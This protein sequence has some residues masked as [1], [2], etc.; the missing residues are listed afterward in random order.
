M[1]DNNEENMGELEF[2]ELEYKYSADD[3]SLEDF[4]KV[5]MNVRKNYPS[6]E[7]RIVEVSSWDT[8][9]TNGKDE[10]IRY[11]DSQVKPELTIKR[12]TQ[13]ANN[14]HRI[15]VNLPLDLR[16]M[17]SEEREK[18]V[19]EFTSLLGFTEN[20][21]IYKTCF[22]YFIGD[23]NYVY[24]IVYDRHMKE[25]RRFLE[26]EFSEER[27]KHFNSDEVFKKLN[28]YESF[29]EPL[30]LKSRNK[31]KKSLFEFFKK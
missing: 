17:C 7:K 13:T 15:E 23:L 18:M 21:K 11:R 2:R 5:M 27:A 26:I 31:L 12:K 16:G 4:R 3:I 22:I 28:E 8:Y 9:Y 6:S 20:F 10:F 25:Q 19:K 1:K 24:Y 30:D 14:N 29:L